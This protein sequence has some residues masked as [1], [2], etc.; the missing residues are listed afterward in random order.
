MVV[1]KLIPLIINYLSLFGN[2]S[3]ALHYLKGYHDSVLDAAYGVSSTFISIFFTAVI[4][5][6]NIGLLP[7]LS[8]AFGA[9]DYHLL[10]I[11][12][13]RGLMTNLFMLI[14]S[15]IFMIYSHKFFIMINYEE[16]LAIHMR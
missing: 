3:F 16:N 8:Q 14:P 15:T 10:G 4:V 1:F 11:C 7:K 13:H 6:L 12:L 9:K 5:S 2:R